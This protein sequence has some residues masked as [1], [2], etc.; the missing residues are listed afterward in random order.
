MLR[1]M[2][3]LTLPLL[4]A[5]VWAGDKRGEEVFNQTCIVCHDT[6]ILNAPRIS[7]GKRWGRLV[8]EGLDDLAVAAL[9]GVRQMP[10]KGANPNLS[11]LEVVRAVV[12]MANR[13]GAGFAEPT[14]AQVE[15]W[16]QKADQRR[17]KS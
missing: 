11:D 2:F 8:A 7:D 3:A 16:R 6:G 1:R 12:W 4:A 17:K 14:L 9:G 15:R 5:P 10:P 13:H